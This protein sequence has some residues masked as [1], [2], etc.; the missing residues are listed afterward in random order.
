M[1]ALT[2]FLLPASVRLG[3]VT[4]ASRSFF[5]FLSVYSQRVDVSFPSQRIL[6]QH[7]SKGI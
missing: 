6:E 7:I 1:D 3:N 5:S 4:F 2:T